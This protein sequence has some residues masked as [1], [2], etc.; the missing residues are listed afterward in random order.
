MTCIHTFEGLS[1]TSHLRQMAGLA[2]P[3]SRCRQRPVALL[4]RPA[5]QLPIRQPTSGAVWATVQRQ[6][7][8]QI[9]FIAAP[10]VGRAQRNVDSASAA[11]YRRQRYKHAH[12]HTHECALKVKQSIMQLYIFSCSRAFVSRTSTVLGTVVDLQ[13]LS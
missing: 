2:P 13:F 3:T 9:T 6:L 4:I 1:V 10:R 8:A 11:A 5:W 12:V 7:H